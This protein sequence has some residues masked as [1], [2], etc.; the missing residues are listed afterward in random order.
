MVSVEGVL[1]A[2]AQLGGLTV[3]VVP[4]QG[5]G[6]S[7]PTPLTHLEDARMSVSRLALGATLAVI[8]LLTSG[9]AYLPLRRALGV[10]PAV[11]MRSE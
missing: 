5:A 1:D 6:V 4:K 10:D 11:A 2:E 8:A 7:L 9:A 3:R